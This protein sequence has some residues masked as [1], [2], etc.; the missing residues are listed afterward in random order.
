M[1]LNIGSSTPNGIYKD[2]PWINID[3]NIGYKDYK[4]NNLVIGSGCSLPFKNNCFDEVRA[5]HVLE[6]LPRNLHL[7]FLSE[8]ARVL[9]PSG[10]LFIEIPN[11]IQIC[12]NIVTFTQALMKEKN[13]ET[14]AIYKELIR[15]ATLSVYGKGRQPFDFHHWGF[16][17]W[18]LGELGTTLGLESALQEEMISGH[19]RQE[20][21]LLMKYTKV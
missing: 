3:A 5:I 15:R 4:G 21:V 14:I 16:S 2:K 9:A 19:Y 11:F 18:S 8:A 6:H 20:P 17:P 7:P 13:P 12:F 1:K 10:V